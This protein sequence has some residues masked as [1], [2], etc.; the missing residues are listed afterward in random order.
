MPS[1][2]WARTV[3][4][5]LADSDVF[6]LLISPD[7]IASAYC[8]ETKMP[9]AVQCYEAVLVP[10]ILRDCPWQTEAFARL[11]AYP[12]DSTPLETAAGPHVFDDLREKVLL[13]LLAAINAPEHAGGLDRFPAWRAAAL[14]ARDPPWL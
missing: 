1:E 3:D 4:A 7:F 12:L 11:E 6:L 5:R 9:R 2:D 8:R 13:A 10:I 14:I